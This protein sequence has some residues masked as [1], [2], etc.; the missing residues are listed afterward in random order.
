MKLTLIICISL[1]AGMLHSVA[2]PI[3]DM[4][5]GLMTHN[6][7]MTSS[8]ETA[9]HAGMMQNDHSKSDN[10]CPDNDYSCC[11]SVTI[12]ST[13]EY[14]IIFSGSEDS[15][16]SP[17]LSHATLRPNAIYRPP[18]FYPVLAG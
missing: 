1:L 10:H 16:S 17:P 3:A 4:G 2:M 9:Q 15:F 18:R 7:E 14:S 11:I 5:V 12:Q 8:H 13:V 6:S